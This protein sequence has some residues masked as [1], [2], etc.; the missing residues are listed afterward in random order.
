M[1][2]EVHMPTG[3]DPNTPCAAR[4]YDCFLGGSHN[5]AVDRAVAQRAIELVPELPKVAQANRA[6]LHR[7]VRVAAGAGLRQFL[8]IGS[9]IPTAGNVHEVARAVR[10]DARVLYVDR[11]PSAVL[12]AQDIL[13]DDPDVRAVQGD[14][15]HPET[16]LE[17]PAARQLFDF[18]Q[19]ICLLMIAVLHFIP[20]G[21]GLTGA[22]HRYREAL[23]PGS[24]LAVSH[25]TGSAR[26]GEVDRVTDLYN[27]TGT[28]LVM[29]DRNA[30]A[31]F[32]EGW[33]PLAP[34]IVFGP[35]WRPDSP[36]DDPAAYLTL[37]GVA[38][39]T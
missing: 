12:L 13:R 33:D 23:A 39:K 1:T 8:D 16:V 15:Q 28:P 22:L 29:R 21:P 24:Y 14:L 4:I 35:Q 25:A 27:R 36:V 18:D 9:G 38:V 32:F 17:H 19:P 30:I 31:G 34:G 11:E 2:S 6:F 20:D 37:A 5:F 7:A 10:P 3:I 26:P